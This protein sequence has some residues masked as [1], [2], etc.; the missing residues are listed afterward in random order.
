MVLRDLLLVLENSR[1]ISR[2]LATSAPTDVTFRETS[3]EG[4]GGREKVGLM[5]IVRGLI[6]KT[7]VL[8][9]PGAAVFTVGSGPDDGERWFFINGIATGRKLATQ[10]ATCINN[11]FGHPVT[12]VHNPT[13]GIFLDLLECAFERTLDQ[14]TN[15][16]DD[17]YDAVMAALLDGKKVRMLGH[18]QGGIS[19]G[20]LLHR[21]QG[22]QSDVL[23]NLE[24]YTF[25]S[26]ADENVKIEGVWQEHFANTDD[27]VSRVGVLNFPFDGTMYVRKSAGHLL[28]RDYLEHF[29]G[30][31]YCGGKSRLFSY[32]SYI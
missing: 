28:N 17:L 9:S 16:S 23:N 20:R 29:I 11:L 10:N 15:V 2:I 14:T 21:L 13:Y 18:S 30:G 19:I 6:T 4:A 24:I 1:Y 31:H 8:R 3:A 25:A 26:A 7:G 22:E 27:F 12:V 5:E 32:L